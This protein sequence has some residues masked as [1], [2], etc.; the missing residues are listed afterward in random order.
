MVD[1]SDKALEVAKRNYE[2]LIEEWKYDLVMK[3]ADLCSF[4][5]D[6]QSDIV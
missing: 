5:A 3:T 6:Y 1:I 4:L 2:N